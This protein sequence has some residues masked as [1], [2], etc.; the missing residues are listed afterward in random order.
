VSVVRLTAPAVFNERASAKPAGDNTGIPL[1]YECPGLA[2]NFRKALIWP[3]AVY[4]NLFKKVFILT[5]FEQR[6]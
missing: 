2:P 3:R 5:L 1:N 4:L 6:G